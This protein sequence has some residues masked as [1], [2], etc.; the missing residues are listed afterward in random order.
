[1]VEPND[2]YTFKAREPFIYRIFLPLLFSN[3]HLGSCSTRLNFPISSCA[4]LTALCVDVLSLIISSF[5]VLH[6]FRIIPSGGKISF[7]R[8]ELAVPLFLWMVL[9]TYMLVPNR[10]IYYPYDFLE[11]MFF[12]I[13]IY[14]ST[15]R[16]GIYVLPI[17]TFIASLNKETALF[18]PLI[19][20]IYAGYTGKLTKASIVSVAVSLLAAFL[21]KYASIYYI[22]NVI[23]TTNT[24][25]PSVFEK[26]FLYNVE[27]LANPIAWLTWLSAFGGCAV[28]LAF[29]RIG[30]KRLNI[31]VGLLILSWTFIVFFVGVS[32]GM[33][34]YGF[35]IFPVL[36]PIML[37]VEEFLYPGKRESESKEL[38]KAGVRGVEVA[39]PKD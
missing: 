15:M 25:S 31:L 6:V 28:F 12:S 27:Q 33:R 3:F 24:T 22:M 10:A 21:G 7:H 9:F 37:Q 16:S 18:L 34:L 4:D 8:P 35:L 11:L 30:Y 26:H 19:Y 29:P 36:L 20:A 14:L 2:F 13:G 5:I 23:G 32:R 38:T 39:A 1:M 17:L